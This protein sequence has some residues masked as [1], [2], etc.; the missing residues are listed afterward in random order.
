MKTYVTNDV[1]EPYYLPEHEEAENNIQTVYSLDAQKAEYSRLFSH[2]LEEVLKYNHYVLSREKTLWIYHFLRMSR[3]VPDFLINEIYNFNRGVFTIQSIPAMTLVVAK[4]YQALGSVHNMKIVENLQIITKI[5]MHIL[6]D[7][8]FTNRTTKEEY[9]M[10]VNLVNTSM[11]L[12]KF[13]FRAVNPD[14]EKTDCCP[15]WLSIFYMCET[16]HQK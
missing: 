16:I 6:V 7:V 12:L 2:N 10:A 5:S 13:N 3:E 4:V 8:I 1:N 11:D 14:H 9:N 15:W